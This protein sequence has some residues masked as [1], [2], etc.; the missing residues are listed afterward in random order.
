MPLL[1][2]GDCPEDIYERISMMAHR[3]HRTIAQQALVLV[4]RALGQE[5]S[6]K[7]RRRLVLEWIE[8]QNVPDAVKQFDDVRSL[9]EDHER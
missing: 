1:Q 3:E 8:A 2:V 4:E 6:N 5:L 9:R 7:E